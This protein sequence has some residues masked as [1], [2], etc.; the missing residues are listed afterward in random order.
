[1]ATLQNILFGAKYFFI[2]V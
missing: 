1:L 2:K